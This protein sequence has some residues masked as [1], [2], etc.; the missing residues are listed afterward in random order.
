MTPGSRRCVVVTGAGQGL[1]RSLALAFAAQGDAVVVSD[2]AAE[3]AAG[4]AEEIHSHGGVASPWAADVASESDIEGL[5]DH[6][7]KQFGVPEVWVNNAG[8]TRPAMLSTMSVS[9]F[10][11][12]VAVH[13]RGTFLGIREAARRMREAEVPGVILNVTSSAG[14]QGTVGQINY[15]AAKGAITAMTKSAAKELARQGIRVNAVAPLAA[16]PMTEKI[17]TDPKFLERYLDQIPLRRFGE[18]DEIAGA[19]TF[20]ASPAGSYITGQVLC[21]DGGLYMAS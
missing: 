12:V 13:V 14:L 17:R 18:P 8:V 1:G 16:T 5:G 2:V 15:S 7:H 19:F 9:D 4:V 21:V 20:L 3:R 11:L 6:A 10:D